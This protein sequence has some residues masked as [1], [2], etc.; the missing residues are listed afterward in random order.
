MTSIV[1]G[2]LP[3]P[4]QSG[5]Q[6]ISK[7][8][9]TAIA[10]LFK[11]TGKIEATVRAEPVAKLL[12]GSVDGFDF[13]GNGMEMY[14]G[15][16]IEAMELY[17]QAVSLDFSAIFRG[18]VKLRQP[19]QA[20]LRVVLSEADLTTS[21]NTAFVVDKLQSL[22]HQGQSLNFENT[23]MLLNE[24]KSLQIISQIRLGDAPEPVNVDVTANLQV[25][26][27]RKLQFVDVTYAGDAAAVELGKAL[28]E[29]VN[30]LLDLDK[31][32]LDGTQLRVDRVRLL[33]KQIIFYGTA[34]IDR[35]PQK[36]K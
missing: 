32:A 8:V 16:R 18:Q 26:E 30:N 36:N 9:S 23:Q 12:Q 20:S 4:N 5:D 28:I 17:V 29:H 15:L 11:R 25:E 3:F 21:F 14:N 7:A 13:I 10:A 19:T 31:F 33:N 6:I 1:F 27:R 34:K 2:S 24:N 35:F 22:Q